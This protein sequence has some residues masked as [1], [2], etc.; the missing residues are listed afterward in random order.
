ML[1]AACLRQDRK[2]F[3]PGD[4]VECLYRGST[5][6]HYGSGEVVAVLD[7]R[8]IVVNCDGLREVDA[9]HVRSYRE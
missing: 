6:L 4:W 5:N 1:T 7:K 2:Q 8:T 9:C 3:G